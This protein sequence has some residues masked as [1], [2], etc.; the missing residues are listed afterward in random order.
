MRYRG[1]YRGPHVSIHVVRARKLWRPY[2]N[3]I[4]SLDAKKRDGIVTH[5][6]RLTGNIRIYSGADDHL[7]T[8]GPIDGLL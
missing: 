5:T 3:Q 4:I 6:I 2:D 7:P 8:D 1:V